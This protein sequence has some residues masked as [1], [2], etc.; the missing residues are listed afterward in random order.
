MKRPMVI[1]CNP[2][3]GEVLGLLGVIRNEAYQVK[4]ICISHGVTEQETALLNT[5]KLMELFGTENIPLI[6]GQKK[7]VRRG[8]TLP[9]GKKQLDDGI[10]GLELVEAPQVNQLFQDSEGFLKELL[11]TSEVP[12]TIL[13]MGPLTDLA[14]LLDTCPAAA[15]HIAQVVFLGGAARRGQI[16]PVC[17][18]NTYLDPEALNLVLKAGVPFVLCPVDV[19]QFA[20]LTQKE[21]DSLY[22]VEGELAHQ[23]HRLLKKLWCEENFS[24]EPWR[25]N[26]ALPVQSLA[27]ALYLAEPSVFHA[28]RYYCEADLKGSLTWGMSVLDYKNSL[29]KTEEEKNALVLEGIEGAPLAAYLLKLAK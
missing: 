7:P 23:L 27:A 19:G 24:E 10:T 6:L 12:V 1:F 17:D 4:G 29:R 20:A 26:K 2:G 18:Q 5:A 3:E 28:T 9:V 16:S 11:L 22:E 14:L 8:N 13:C 15:G 25:R 21:I